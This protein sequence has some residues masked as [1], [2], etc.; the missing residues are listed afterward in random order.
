MARGLKWAIG[1]VALCAAVVVPALA[2][3]ADPVKGGRYSGKSRP[4]L[5]AKKHSVVIRV[6]GDGK[7][8]TMRY[9]GDRPR[10]AQ[11]VRFRIRDGRFRATKRI[12]RKGRRVVSFQATGT[13][14][15]RSRVSGEIVV[16]F[17]CDRMPG[18]F[19]ARLRR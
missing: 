3:A 13:F 7:R 6:S 18:P 1:L 5:S 16:V 15:T 19:S 14:R 11:T 4:I 10:R 8:G 2:L 12:R 17:R 9:C